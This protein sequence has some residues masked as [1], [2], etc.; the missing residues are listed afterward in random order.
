[1]TPE[2]S[3]IR[4]AEFHTWMK[5]NYGYKHLMNFG[6]ETFVWNEN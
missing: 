1:M 3:A 5:A 6:H 4:R 2:K